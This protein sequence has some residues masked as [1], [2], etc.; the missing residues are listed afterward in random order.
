V[1]KSRDKIKPQNYNWKISE[2]KDGSNILTQFTKDGKIIE[3]FRGD[4]SSFQD[5]ISKI[6][7]AEVSKGFISFED[8]KKKLDNN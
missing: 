2:S 6:E 8:F 1:G 4:I 5:I 7:S 3:E